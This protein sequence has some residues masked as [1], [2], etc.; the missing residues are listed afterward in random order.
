MLAARDACRF[1]DRRLPAGART[2]SAVGDIGNRTGAVARWLRRVELNVRATFATLFRPPRS[3]FSRPSI[4]HITIGAALAVVSISAAMML[5]D[6]GALSAARHMP[7]KAVDAFRG[8]TYLGLSGWFLWPTGLLLLAV[9]LLDSPSLPRCSRTVRAAWAVR[10]GFVF[11]AVAVPG[12][13]VTIVKRLIGRARP[14]V[15]GDD[16]WAY[17]PLGWRVDYASF[18]S[19]HAT[20]AFSALV[21]IGALFPATRA[22]MWTYAVLIALSRVVVTAHHPS[23]VIAGA[24]VGAFGALL[25]RDW[26]ASR[27]LAFAVGRTGAVHPMPGPSFGR[28]VRA[29]AG[30]PPSV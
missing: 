19:G 15:A 1:G 25:V 27:R 28:I 5:L 16:V 11:T 13:F 26:F 8:F 18:P 3:R 12:L 17:L 10:L 14:F 7:G 29:I 20:T 6:G 4:G 23:D 21:A 24:I 30:R 22:L 9:L 2:M